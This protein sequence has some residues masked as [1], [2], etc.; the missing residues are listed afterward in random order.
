MDEAL[1]RLGQSE[2]EGRIQ[3]DTRMMGRG[4]LGV[5]DVS[6]FCAKDHEVTIPI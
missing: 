5:G 6:G 4:F 3:F 1:K 2:E